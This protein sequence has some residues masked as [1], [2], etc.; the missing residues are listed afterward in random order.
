LLRGIFPEENEEKEQN[1][2]ENKNEN[3]DSLSPLSPF[4]KEW[5]KDLSLFSSSS[6]RR[7]H[8]NH[9]DRIKIV[10]HSSSSF[11][12]FPLKESAALD[13]SVS[14][15]NNHNNKNNNNNNSSY[16]SQD[17]LELVLDKNSRTIVLPNYSSLEIM[18]EKLQSLVQFL[19][20]K[21]GE[22]EESKKKEIVLES[23]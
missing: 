11:S 22:E 12:S 21:A 8:H 1:E 6:V 9:H 14:W 10:P 19:L 18:K 13:L 3:N 15:D 2:N 16:Y 5:K 7:D 4:L 17:S 20:E 23:K